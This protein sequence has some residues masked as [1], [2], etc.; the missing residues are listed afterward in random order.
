MLTVLSKDSDPRSGEISYRLEKIRRGEPDAALM[1]VPADYQQ[2]QP[3]VPG[4][5]R[6]PAAPAAPKPPAKG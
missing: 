6:T 4:T 2:D 5:P 3:R 1:K